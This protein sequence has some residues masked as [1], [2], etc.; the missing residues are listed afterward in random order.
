MAK[1]I[2]SSDKYFMIAIDLLGQGLSSHIQDPLL[3]NFKTFVYSI[4]CVVKYLNLKNF[5]MMG[6]S[7]GKFKLNIK[8][9]LITK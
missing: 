6:H 5:V 3:Y 1:Y 2:C 4:R 7:G 9:N 8:N